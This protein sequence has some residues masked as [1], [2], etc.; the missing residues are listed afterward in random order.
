MVSEASGPGGRVPHT[1]MPA[2]CASQS[3]TPTENTMRER[4]NGLTFK[5]AKKLTEGGAGRT[6]PDTPQRDPYT[7]PN[8]SVSGIPRE[9]A[10]DHGTPAQI[11]S[12]QQLRPVFKHL[13]EDF[14]SPAER[15][16]FF[17]I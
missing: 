2:Q 3:A 7:F 11:T 13:P 10:H 4:V 17:Q 5:L 8:P 12:Q 15:G 1:A 6:L 16:E 14:H 9:L